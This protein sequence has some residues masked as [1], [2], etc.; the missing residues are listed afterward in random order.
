MSDN[1]VFSGL[2][3]AN[4]LDSGL[5]SKPE[6]EIGGN[7]G[8]MAPPPPLQV[9]TEAANGGAEVPIR[10]NGGPTGP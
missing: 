4:P 6:V 3:G 1:S 8:P 9:D 2:G 10:G 5:E 7:G